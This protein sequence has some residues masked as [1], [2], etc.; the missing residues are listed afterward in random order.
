MQIKQMNINLYRISLEKIWLIFKTA[1]FYLFYEFYL[2]YKNAP[3][4]LP[5]SSRS[6]S[7]FRAEQRRLLSSFS[8]DSDLLKFNQLKVRLT[9]HQSKFWVLYHKSY[10]EYI[11][12]AYFYAL[13]WLPSRVYSHLTVPGIGSDV[14][15]SWHIYAS[16]SFF[17]IIIR[18][19][20]TFAVLLDSV[21]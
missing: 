5:S 17:K 12:I 13:D 14:F 9:H 15:Y 11:T 19:T 18:F 16:S 4:Q 21:P 20:W 3:A 2:P 10:H 7:D 1:T 6:G 8:C